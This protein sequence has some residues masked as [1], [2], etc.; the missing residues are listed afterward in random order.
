MPTA[1]QTHPKTYEK[2][3]RRLDRESGLSYLQWLRLYDDK[4]KACKGGP[5][6][7]GLRTKSSFKDNYYY[8]DLVMNRPH[9]HT[10]QLKHP[11][12]GELREPIRQFAAAATFRDKLWTDKQAVQE[13]FSARGHKAKYI[14]TLVQYV[15]RR[16][17]YLHLWQ[18][19]VLGGI[20]DL[21]ISPLIDFED[22]LSPEQVRIGT[23]VNKF[24]EQRKEFYS[25][26]PEACKDSCESDSDSNEQLPLDERKAC[27]LP[28][29][30]GYDWR[31]FLLVRGKTFAL[32]RCIRKALEQNYRVVCA[33][34]T[35]M[36]S[37]V[38]NAVIS[39][40]TF[41]ANKVHSPF[42]YPV[43]SSERPQINWDRGNYDLLVLDE[44]SMISST[45][46]DYVLATLQQLQV[47]PV[48]SLRGDQQQQH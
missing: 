38:Y 4:G 39:K 25:D 22:N 14:E 10:H 13:H 7:V 11:R 33:T 16:L 40:S 18:R 43:N 29:T 45:I 48:V 5:T 20:A 27:E 8:Q 34:P 35:G 15:Q 31:K 12:H 32:L 2:Y 23:L 9:K 17:D 1:A 26:I 19:R 28:A 36:L 46:F 6:L 44:L 30:S 37:S 24:L 21:A 47:R 3:Y 42:K 41:T